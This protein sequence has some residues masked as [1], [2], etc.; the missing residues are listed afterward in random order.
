GNSTIQQA[1][2][3]TL[4]SRGVGIDDANSGWEKVWRSACWARLNETERAYY[5]LRLSIQNNWAPNGLS[6]YS[7]H[8][9][10]FQIDANFGFVGAVLSMLVVDMPM[11]DYKDSTRTVILG[12]AIPSDWANGS[13]RGLRLRGGGSVDFSWDDD[14]V[15]TKATLDCSSKKV[16]VINK[17][18]DV[19]GSSE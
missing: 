16:K 1:V 4:W 7:G 5:E 11:L 6:M 9:E 12:P 19:L 14:G 10:P 13:V 3:T 18:G 15:V 8:S 2:A 17:N